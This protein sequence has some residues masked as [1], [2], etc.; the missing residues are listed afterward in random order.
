MSIY[1][2]AGLVGVVLMALFGALALLP[3]EDTHAH[4]VG[5]HDR[6][7]VIP[8]DERAPL[9][10]L[11][12]PVGQFWRFVMPDV[13]SAHYPFPKYCGHGNFVKPNHY[14]YY[15]GSYWSGGFH[16]HFGRMNH[17]VG[18]DYRYDYRCGSTSH[19]YKTL[20]QGWF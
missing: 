10:R 7:V 8:A 18:S 16:Y 5:P 2:K 13:A 19:H 14:F 4:S 1:Q 12:E 11:S 15:G 17:V 3:P 9:A 6:L 20:P